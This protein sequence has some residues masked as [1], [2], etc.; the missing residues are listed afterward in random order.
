M[1]TTFTGEV[2][3]P[4]SIENGLP[5]TIMLDAQTLVLTAGGTEL[6]RWNRTDLKLRREADGTF[7][8]TLG[9]EVVLFNPDSPLEFAILSGMPGAGT[10]PAPATTAVDELAAAPMPPTAPSAAPTVPAAP[11]PAAPIAA[12]PASPEPPAAPPAVPAAPA[13]AAVPPTPAAPSPSPS[14]PPP[15]A[16]QPAP[17]TPPTEI[18]APVAAQPAVAPSVAAIPPG[19]AASPATTPETPGVV[20]GTVSSAPPTSPAPAASA[21]P[22]TA[23]PLPVAASTVPPTPAVESV[24]PQAA[25]AVAPIAAAPAAAVEIQLEQS[26]GPAG[27]DGPVA[28]PTPPGAQPIDPALAFPLEAAPGTDPQPPAAAPRSG[29]AKD[30][31]DGFYAEEQEAAA[32]PGEPVAVAEVSA[33]EAPADQASEFHLEDG[34]EGSVPDDAAEDDAAKVGGY[35]SGLFTEDAVT[36]AEVPAFGAGEPA[37]EDERGWSYY[38]DADREQ[39]EDEPGWSYNDDQPEEAGA[40]DADAG[41][42]ADVASDAADREELVV[43]AKTS[44]LKGITGWRP[45]LPSFG[46]GSSALGMRARDVLGMLDSILEEN[47]TED[48]PKSFIIGLGGFAILLGVVAVLVVAFG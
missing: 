26:T 37:A 20:S 23:A 32:M 35:G 45:S 28:A 46:L 44:R 6:G 15:A 39:A 30:F 5:S 18:A 34:R 43:T 25:A 33:G 13:A 29:Q 14:T 4:G 24:A 31:W 38:D 22:P 3:I 11:V 2:R 47:G 40:S 19:P 1:T 7:H 10:A 21:P 9:R 17:T 12:V 36:A 41:D 42:P 8:L 48:I 27:G 16:P